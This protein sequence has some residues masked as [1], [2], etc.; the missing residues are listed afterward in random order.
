MQVEV[1]SKRGNLSGESQLLRNLSVF[2]QSNLSPGTALEGAWLEKEEFLYI[3][4][5]TYHGVDMRKMEV[6]TVSGKELERERKRDPEC[7]RVVAYRNADANREAGEKLVLAGDMAQIRLV[8]KIEPYYPGLPDDG[9]V[10]MLKL[11]PDDWN[12]ELK[13]RGERIVFV[14]Q[15]QKEF[16]AMDLRFMTYDLRARMRERVVR[17]LDCKQVRVIPNAVCG[18]LTPT[19]KG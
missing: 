6:R 2:L 5:V 15:P 7:D 1:W 10:K 4:D 9:S 18:N 13:V 16:K 11:P 3:F 12:L 14:I 8:E 19:E 17:K